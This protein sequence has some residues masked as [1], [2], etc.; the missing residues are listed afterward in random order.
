MYFCLGNVGIGKIVSGVC[1]YNN[2][3]RAPTTQGRYQRLQFVEKGSAMW[4][5][6]GVQ[7]FA[8]SS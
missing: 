2:R 5:E 4:Q 1:P 7:K 3:H 8:F 6:H